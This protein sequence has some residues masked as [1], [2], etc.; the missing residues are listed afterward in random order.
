MRIACTVHN[1]FT[2]SS[3][4]FTSR[5]WI[6]GKDHHC[7]YIPFARGPPDGPSAL[8]ALV[9]LIRGRQDMG[10]KHLGTAAKLGVVACAVVLTAAACSSD[11]NTTSTGS[12]A[13]TAAGASS[14]GAK[15]IALLLPETK[16]ARYETQDKPLFE[17]KVKSLCSD[18][19]V[20]YS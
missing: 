14:G 20:L 17:A 9:A 13:T 3:R 15:K 11:S 18:C 1:S 6:V 10:K 19:E 8:D 2:C 16:T 5:S 4:S 12:G 7:G